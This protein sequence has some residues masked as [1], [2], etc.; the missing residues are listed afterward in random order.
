MPESV[1]DLQRRIKM[2]VDELGN[3]A[4]YCR[5]S[6][7]KP[8]VPNWVEFEDK[9]IAAE[10]VIR[11]YDPNRVGLPDLTPCPHCGWIDHQHNSMIPHPFEG[12]AKNE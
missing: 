3:L 2:L 10:A 1:E 4:G 9:I 6:M 12:P 11:I 7:E 8:G 5:W